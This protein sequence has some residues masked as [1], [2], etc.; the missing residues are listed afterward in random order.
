[1]LSTNLEVR[2]EKKITQGPRPGNTILAVTREAGVKGK[3]WGELENR[4][5][6]RVLFERRILQTSCE[7]KGGV[8][9]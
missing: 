4:R 1:M 2:I 5:E 9:T 6:E 7:G 8:S 3:R